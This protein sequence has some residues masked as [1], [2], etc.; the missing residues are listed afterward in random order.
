MS[1]DLLGLTKRRAR[2]IHACI[3]CNEKIQQGE[4]YEDEASVY[5][6]ELQRLRW[7]PECYAAAQVWFREFGEEEFEPHACKRG[8]SEERGLTPRAPCAIVSGEA[9][10]TTAEGPENVGRPASG[11]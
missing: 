10:A 8:T 5:Y 3:W 11:H 1:Y 4:T 6:G 7:H 2:K 9:K